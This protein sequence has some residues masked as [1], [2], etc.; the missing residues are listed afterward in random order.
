MTQDTSSVDAIFFDFDGV[1]VDSV[2][3]KERVFHRMM[4]QHAGDQ[5]D[6]CMAYYQANGGVSR[7][8]KLQ[9]I[10]ADI[11]HRPLSDELLATLG[12]EFADSVYQAVVECDLVPGVAEFLEKWSAAWACYVISGTPEA[13][14]RSIVRARG[15]ERCF[16]GVYG[17]P[18]TK[19][20]I[21]ERIL[22]EHGY[23]PRRVWF[24]GDA[25]TDRDAAR[26]LGTRFVGIDGPH[27]TPFLDGQERT[28]RSLVELEGVL[29]GNRSAT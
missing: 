10:W 22:R 17:S 24:I 27:L 21:G 1:I 18:P 8:V 11:L 3:L 19:I 16:R 5:V 29:L 20:E 2:R 15:M 6:E 25:T 14:L 26:A 7:I 12:R 28:I 13:E 9:R 23:D 4:L